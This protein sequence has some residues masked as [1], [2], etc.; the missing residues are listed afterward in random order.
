MSDTAHVGEPDWNDLARD[1]LARF[2][3]EAARFDDDGNLLLGDN[4]NEIV[5]DDDG[6]PVVNPLFWAYRVMIEGEDTDK[7]GNKIKVYYSPQETGQAPVEPGGETW[8][9]GVGE[10]IA[11]EGGG[12][13]IMFMEK[14]S[15]PGVGE[16]PGV[17]DIERSSPALD[18]EYLDSLTDEQLE[19]LADGRA[20]GGEFSE[21]SDDP[22]R[23]IYT[24]N[25]KASGKGGRVLV[26]GA[27]HRGLS[28][29]GFPHARYSIFG[30]DDMYFM[31]V[32][33]DKAAN[34]RTE[35]NKSVGPYVR[36][37]MRRV[38]TD[39]NGSGRVLEGDN[40]PVAKWI[41]STFFGDNS[42]I[43]TKAF[44]EKDREMFKD[45]KDSGSWSALLD[46]LNDMDAANAMD[47]G[48]DEKA[49]IASVARPNNRVTQAILHDNSALEGDD[50]GMRDFMHD[51]VV[52]AI[53]RTLDKY[54]NGDPNTDAVAHPAGKVRLMQ[55]FT[56]LRALDDEN[57]AYDNLYSVDDVLSGNSSA[58]RD[59]M[60]EYVVDWMRTG[61]DIGSAEEL[62]GNENSPLRKYWL[63]R[64]NG[65]PGNVAWNTAL[66][67]RFGDI[68]YL[69]SDDDM[70]AVKSGISRGVEP[71]LRRRAIIRGLTRG[72]GNG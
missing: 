28:V 44:T 29:I 58:Q 67:K 21:G 11:N 50:H 23:G 2:F 8:E 10:D 30:N 53:M 63:M 1:D 56:P 54:A 40:S 26:S 64:L 5:Y 7:N 35:G 18:E 47:E 45:V 17:Y 62:L 60:N 12:G 37:A 15:V 52:E 39:K 48:D 19:A 59:Y 6:N 70:K 31:P 20:V 14:Q 16:V 33:G 22:G 65:V 68:R 38:W 9:Y 71:L 57:Q 46:R 55:V 41:T 32:K 72:P 27:P 34:G 66:G 13:S 24:L 69:I 4:F 42:P 49:D 36:D 51:K 43:W 61:N 3:M 25:T